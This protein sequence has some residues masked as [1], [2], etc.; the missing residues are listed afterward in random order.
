MGRRWTGIVTEE[1]EGCQIREIL[2][3]EIGLTRRQISRVKFFRDGILVNGE[4]KRVTE[5]VKAGE[6][7]SVRISEEEKTGKTL[8]AE[9]GRVCVLYEDADLLLVKK[10]S[11]MVCHPGHGHY[12]DSLANHVARYLSQRGED[13]VIREVGRLDRDTS[14]IVVFAKNRIAAARLAEQ[15]RKG[16]FRKQYVAVVR[17][18]FDEREGEIRLPIG[19]L[20][21]SLMKMAVRADGKNA[22][23]RY[24]VIAEEGENSVVQCTLETGRTHQIR[25]HM[26][27]MG[28]PILGDC[29]YGEEAKTESGCL[30]LHA[31]KVWLLQPFTG[32]KIEAE[33]RFTKEERREQEREILFGEKRNW[34]CI[35]KNTANLPLYEKRNK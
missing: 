27:E 10:E 35:K 31:Q 21:G 28:H 26:A 13:S 2:K 24:K 17:G 4:Q 5:T 12:T 34:E 7:L 33:W 6:V 18:H 22:V 25:V 14:G 20:E 15:R 19:P 29:L 32:V 9:E 16:R 8:E 23:T 3:K 30:C 11:G 1:M